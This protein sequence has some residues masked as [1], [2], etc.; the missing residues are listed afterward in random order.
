MGF[1][2]E[3]DSA[4]LIGRLTSQVTRLSLVQCRVIF[5]GVFFQIEQ[6]SPLINFVPSM[7]QTFFKMAFFGYYLFKEEQYAI[8]AGFSFLYLPI[9]FYYVE[10]SGA[11]WLK[12]QLPMQKAMMDMYSVLA[13]QLQNVPTIKAFNGYKAA[14]QSFVAQ[15]RL[16]FFFLFFFVF[17]VLI[18]ELERM[19][20]LF[21]L[22]LQINRSARLNIYTSIV[23]KFA[24]TALSLVMEANNVGLRQV[25]F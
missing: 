14:S 11:F 6:M 15:V 22:F 4:G 19:T 20:E 8:L 12:W 16:F 21:F 25:L 23:N 2:E 5:I 18:L 13:E 3:R 17:G 1:F 9:Y 24:E 10:W 7:T